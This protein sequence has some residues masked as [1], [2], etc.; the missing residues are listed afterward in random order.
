MELYCVSVML[1]LCTFVSHTSSAPPSPFP[2]KVHARGQAIH[3]DIPT[4]WASSGAASDSPED[5]ARRCGL[6]VHKLNKLLPADVL[7][8]NVSAA[9]RRSGL[10]DGDLE[11]PWH[12]MIASTGKLYSYRW[13]CARHM[14]PLDRRD[15]ALWY[16]G[17]FDVD[18]LEACLPRF[19][20][21]R[22]FASFA[23][24]LAHTQA[25][26][27]RSSS[28]AAGPMDTRRTV[29]S[30]KLVREGCGGG[31][32]PGAED[33]RLDFELDGALYKMVRNI[34]GAMFEVSTGELNLDD[35]DEIFAHQDRRL[36]PSRAAPAAG[37]TLEHV[38]YDDF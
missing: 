5:D 8:W 12:A 24:R 37:L 19:E 33:Y 22:D 6:L 1:S 38:Y 30:I 29:R 2:H 27:D 26:R 17:G 16:K 31:G 35:I 3:F 18:R 9:P 36:N 20:G 11:L 21:T 7:L 13:R 23:N 32:S 10:V 25:I 14:S 34:V 15:R 4:T 28:G